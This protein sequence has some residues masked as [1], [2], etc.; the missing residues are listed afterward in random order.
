MNLFNVPYIF[1]VDS[2][3]M[4]SLIVWQD[5]KS[6]TENR[7]TVVLQNVVTLPQHDMASQPRIAIA[8][9]TWNLAKQNK[10]ISFKMSQNICNGCSV[11]ICDGVK[12]IQE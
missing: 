8:I 7:G 2:F 12:N 11:P 4:A 1:V 3:I 5:T 6:H 10:Y 9:N